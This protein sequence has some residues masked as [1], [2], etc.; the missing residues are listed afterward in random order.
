[1]CNVYRSPNSLCD[2]D[3]HLSELINNLCRTTK[4][5]MLIVGD[6]NLSDIDWEIYTAPNNN[7][8]SQLFIKVLKDNLITQL[9]DTPTSGVTTAVG[10]PRQEFVLGPLKAILFLCSLPYHQLWTPDT[11]PDRPADRSPDGTVVW[12]PHNGRQASNVILQ[13]E[14]AWATEPAGHGTALNSPVRLETW[15]A[16]HRL[17][18]AACAA[19]SVRLY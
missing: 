8:S 1:V 15:A 17:V 9:V 12:I 6:F 3:T 13:L 2:N 18:L 16:L 7:L 19:S 10:P 14:G 4:G 5:D 11:T